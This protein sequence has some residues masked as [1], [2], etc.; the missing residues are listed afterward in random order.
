MKGEVSGER[1]ERGKCFPA[2]LV[3]TSTFVFPRPHHQT[4]KLFSLALLAL[5]ALATAN[6]DP[7]ESLEGVLDLGETEIE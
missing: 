5:A 4:M 2:R 6:S 1:S 7:T 3:L